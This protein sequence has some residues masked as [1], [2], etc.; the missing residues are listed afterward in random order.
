VIVA[1][2]AMSVALIAGAVALGLGMWWMR[3]ERQQIG[4]REAVADRL[5]RILGRRET[6]LR[7][8]ESAVVWAERTR[9]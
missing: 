2:T 6:E 3:E 8:R 1:M 4:E 9:R 5:E 7:H